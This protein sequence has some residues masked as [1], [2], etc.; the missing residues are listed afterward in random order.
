MEQHR[1]HNVAKTIYIAAARSGGGKSLAELG[2]RVI[3]CAPTVCAH[4]TYSGH[5]VWIGACSAITRVL[6]PQVHTA[7]TY[8][9]TAVVVYGAYYI[10]AQSVGMK[11]IIYIYEY[12]SMCINV[13]LCKYPSK[14]YPAS[15]PIHNIM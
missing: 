15:P 9:L 6:F 14:A 11:Y 5:I 3:F 7:Y 12:D 8:T 4:Y 1:Q 10:P 2:C 13:K